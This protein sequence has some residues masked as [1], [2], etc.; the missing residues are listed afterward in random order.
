MLE[1][2]INKV[3]VMGGPEGESGR[4]GGGGGEEKSFWVFGGRDKR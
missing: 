4:G 1:E 3:L 2:R